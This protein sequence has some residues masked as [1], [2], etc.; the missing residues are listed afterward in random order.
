MLTVLPPTR[1]IYVHCKATYMYSHVHIHVMYYCHVHVH[2]CSMNV[3]VILLF[4]TISSEDHV[5][6]KR[7]VS[8]Q[9]GS[10]TAS[11]DL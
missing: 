3:L 4:R 5:K 10:Q 6:S 11:T 2:V 1:Y 7:R 9:T 8:D